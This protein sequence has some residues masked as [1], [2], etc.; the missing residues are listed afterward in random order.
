[1]VRNLLSEYF[2]HILLIL[3]KKILFSQGF[4]IEHL[5]REDTDF[6]IFI[7]PGVTRQAGFLAGMFQERYAV[8]AVVRGDLR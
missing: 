2:L 3:S 6:G 5:G 7:F 8:P 1:M 4:P